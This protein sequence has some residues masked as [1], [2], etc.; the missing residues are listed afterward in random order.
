MVAPMS[1]DPRAKQVPAA[2][3]APIIDWCGRLRAAGRS[4]ETIRTRTDHLRRAA[5][6]L[7]GDPWTVSAEQLVAWVG[8]E[9]W[10]RE[11]RRS[12]YASLRSFWGW[13]VATGRCEV[14]PAATLPSVKPEPP[15][16]RPTP[17][18]IYR[19]ALVRADERER[20]ILQLAAHAGLRRA[21]IAKVHRTDLIEDLAGWSLIVHG[22]GSRD[23]M[24]P[25][26]QW[27]AWSVRQHLAESETGWLFPG[28]VGGHLSPQTVGIL[29]SR[30]LPT[31]WTLHTLRHRFASTA[32]AGD[33]DLISVSQLLGHASV[34]TTQRYVRPPDGAL[35]RAVEAAA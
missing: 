16:P 26:P 31:G 32:Y 7:G 33:R 17:E 15:L 30:L 21:E 10:R 18:P 35:R 14:S 27:L 22:K 19:C 29:A 2:W 1:S 12:V 24:I 9:A 28:A 11:T 4:E 34:A 5:R 25:L 13:A 23:R 6:V 20:L 8:G 3:R